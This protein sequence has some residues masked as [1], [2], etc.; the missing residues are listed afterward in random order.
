MAISFSQVPS[1]LRV[2]GAYFEVSNN[3]AQSA[4]DQLSRILVFG[5]RL[6]TGTVD[7][8]VPTLVTSKEDAITF[9]GRGSNLANMFSTLFDNNSFTEKWCVALDDDAVGV[10]ATGTLT[11]TA[12][13]TIAGTISLYVAGVLVQ[14]VVATGDAQNA[15]A[16]AIRD[17]INANLDLPVTATVSTNVVTVTARHKGTIGNQIDLRLNYRGALNGEVMPSG[18]SI[19]IVDMASGATDPDIDDA[20]AV[21]PDEIYGYWLEPWT[22]S[23]NLNALDTELNRR[24]GPT[25]QLEGHVFTAAAGSVGTLST[26]GNSRNNQ[27]MTIYDAASNSPTPAYLW[28]SALVGQV[29]FA[30]TNDPARPFNTLPQVGI[31]AEPAEDRRT[32]SERNTLLY[33]GIATHKVTQSGEVQ[34]ERVITTYQKNSADVADSSYLDANTLF[35]LSYL[36][37]SLRVLFTSKFP[38][39]K[40]ADDGTRFGAGQPIMTPKIAKSEIVALAGMWEENGLIEDIEAFKTNLIVERDTTDPTRLNAVIPPDLVNGFQILAAVIEFRL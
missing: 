17:A 5:Q 15:I 20:I 31:L 2:P 37:Q 10:Q 38:R 13:S 6:S 30:A 26:L 28:A 4:L 33:D 12:S 32:F 3:Q 14:I 7:E 36:R 39:H 24:W 16:T 34:I 1:N 35:T 40:L 21:L 11:V 8:L 9:F 27:H 29:A 23:A 18:V 22:G 25:V 19:A